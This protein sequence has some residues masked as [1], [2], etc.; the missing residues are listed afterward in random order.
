MKDVLSYND[1]AL[2]I[3]H[4]QTNVTSYHKVLTWDEFDNILKGIRVGNILIIELMYIDCLSI[5]KTIELDISEYTG[6]T[7]YILRFIYGSPK[8]YIESKIREQFTNTELIDIAL[9]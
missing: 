6:D 7:K 5:Y 4:K 9:E 1:D 2:C 3:T 8:G